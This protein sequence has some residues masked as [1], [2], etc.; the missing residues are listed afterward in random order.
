MSGRP[1]CQRRGPRER[2]RQPIP[3]AFTC[4][5]PDGRAV[6]ARSAPYRERMDDPA[7]VSDNAGPPAGDRCGRKLGVVRAHGGP[8]CVLHGHRV[9]HRAHAKP[10][11]RIC[12]A[13]GVHHSARAWRRPKDPQRSPAQPPVDP[14]RAGFRTGSRSQ[15]IVTL[16][17]H[18]DTPSSR[19]QG[20]SA[21]RNLPARLSFIRLQSRRRRA[22]GRDLASEADSRPEKGWCQG[23][24][25]NHCRVT[26]PDLQSGA[27]D[28][29]ATLAPGR[30]GAG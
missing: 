23:V 13:T 27:F 19:R 2:A 26:P 5:G 25:S 9:A 4:D 28:R 10:I 24:D 3:G 7:H 15:W 20:L 17:E 16:P 6:F 1:T 22:E 8:V 14:V 29:S 30:T 12:H 11:A 18:W 21:Y